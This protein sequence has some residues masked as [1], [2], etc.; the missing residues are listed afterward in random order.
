MKDTD[1]VA[2][3]Q[4]CLPRLQLRW[5]GFRKVRRQV[6][7]RL[8]RRLR[9]LNLPDTSAYRAYLET[10][11]AEWTA[12]DAMCRITISRFYRD[13]GVFET[14]RRAIL[15][16]L[17]QRITREGASTLRCWS[18]GCASGEEA[19]TLKII[20]GHDLPARFS[21]LDLHIM[22]TDTEIPMLER[23]RHG[24]YAKGTL[25]E[26]PA[27]WIDAAF[28]SIDETYCIRGAYRTGITWAQQDIRRT[29]PEGPFHLILCRNIVFTYFD[30]ALQRACL[31]RMADRLLPGGF[32]VLGKHESLPDPTTRFSAW[33]RQEDIYQRM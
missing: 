3:L 18:A 28:S 31:A 15:P 9:S 21:H 8:H 1:C 22:A 26:L 25:K 7:K 12:L 6:C 17:V 29:M 27:G 16:D 10:H 13:R 30:D 19:Y 24:C 2:F 14:L 4:W 23:A 32:L 11:P 5:P 20:W 33:N